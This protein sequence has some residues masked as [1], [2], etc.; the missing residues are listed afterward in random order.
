VRPLPRLRYPQ[1]RIDTPN[2]ILLVLI[3]YGPV[4][5]V[6]LAML[7]VLPGMLLD[8][9]TC[10]VKLAVDG[11]NRNLSAI[12]LASVSHYFC[13]RATPYLPCESFAPTPW[14]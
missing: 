12:V 5:L 2:P 11:L 6:A 7:I 9:E 8:E 1:R 10:T 3:N 13:P 4:V 14:P